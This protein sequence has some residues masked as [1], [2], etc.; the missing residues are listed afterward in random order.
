MSHLICQL[1]SEVKILRRQLRD[2]S[3]EQELKSKLADIERRIQQDACKQKKYEEKLYEIQISLEETLLE[4][5]IEKK[6]LM[7]KLCNEQN[8]NL[9]RKECMKRYV[10]EIQCLKCEILDLKEELDAKCMEFLSVESKGCG[11][12]SK[13]NELIKTLKTERCEYKNMCGN[14]KMDLEKRREAERISEDKIAELKEELRC[15][16]QEVI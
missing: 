7:E 12:L 3:S 15:K 2:N 8:E 4:H 16:T 14:L 9:K 13:T 6:K 11:E 1:K 5:D 10:E